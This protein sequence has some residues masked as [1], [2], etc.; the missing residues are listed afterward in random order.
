M[1]RH[2][3]SPPLVFVG[4]FYLSALW[5]AACPV[6]SAQE[7]NEGAV[8]KEEEP[9]Y[10]PTRV[11]DAAV[12]LEGDAEVTE[13]VTKVEDA[14]GA[15]IVSIDRRAGTRV[16]TPEYQRVKVS[17]KGVALIE[18][19]GTKFDPLLWELQLPAKVG[20][21]WNYERASDGGKYFDVRVIQGVE[22]VK[23]PAG[24]FKAVKVVRTRTLDNRQIGVRWYAPEVGLV[25]S[26]YG[27]DTKVL[28]S[29]TPGKKSK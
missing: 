22:T 25:K 4:F 12:Y 21:E 17:A 8:V 29:F 14:E 5:P 1:K 23:V 19:Y 28:K 13:T 27:K 3:S 6:A 10:F 11:G 2:P 7:K 26:E 18:L 20:S 24:R 9:L 15:K 16:V